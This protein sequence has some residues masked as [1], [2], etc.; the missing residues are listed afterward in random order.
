MASSWN[1][2]PGFNNLGESCEIVPVFSDFSKPS[3]RMTP[4]LGEV[5][6]GTQ[7]LNRLMQILDRFLFTS[8]N[9]VFLCTILLEKLNSLRDQDDIKLPV[10]KNL[11]I[12]CPSWPLSKMMNEYALSPCFLGSRIHFPERGCHSG[13]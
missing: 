13:T 1:L 12:S 6:P 2:V 4:S 5:N 9:S 11:N 7:K 8:Y 10:R 3:S